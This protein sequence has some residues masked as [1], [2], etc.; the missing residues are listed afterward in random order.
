[1]VAACRLQ[2]GG[3]QALHPQRREPGETSMVKSRRRASETERN[4]HR[5]ED[6]ER[7]KRAAEQLLSSDGWQRWVRARSRNGLAR[8]SVSNLLLILLANPDASYV[9]GFRAWIELGYCVRKGEHGIRIL[10]PIRRRSDDNTDDQRDDTDERPKIRFQSI[11]VFD[12][13][14][15]D[16]LADRE[17]A[18][19]EPPCEPLTGDS[20]AHLLEPAFRFA[21]SIG[22]MIGLEAMPS[23]TGGWC[24]HTTK[25]IAIDQAAAPNAQL[26]T[27]VH[28]IAH[29]LGIDYATYTREQAEVMVDAATL[30]VCAGLGLATDGE[31]IPYIAGWGEN[32][33]LEAITTF[34]GVIDSTARRIEAAIA[35]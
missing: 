35:A 5:A 15:V 2:V 31:T 34:A 10:A 14:Q 13:T 20:H 19:L 33:A 32:G 30:I 27:T 1:M 12:R 3:H 21:E 26:R 16:V 9:A 24:N 7:L 6:R 8:Y 29:A 17:P 4:A 18:P 23:G 25:R 22:Y 28:E 11:A